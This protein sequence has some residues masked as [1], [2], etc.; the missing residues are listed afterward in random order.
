MK[1]SEKL[2][3][4]GIGLGLYIT[5]KIIKLY[6]GHIVCYSQYGKGTTFVFIVP[7]GSDNEDNTH[8]GLNRIKNPAALK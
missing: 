7:L 2:N 3:T 6:D 1:S 5:K 8:I 4:K